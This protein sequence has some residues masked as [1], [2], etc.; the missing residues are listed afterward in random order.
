MAKDKYE[1]IKL[2]N[3]VCFPIYL[4]SKEI[5]KKYNPLLSEL[6]LTY[7]QY[8]VMMFFWERESSNLKE[9][10]QTLMIDPSTL[11]PLLKKIE[12]KGYIKRERAKDDERNLVITLTE[13][14]EALKD[15]ALVIPDK[16]RKCVDMSDDEI[17]QLLALTK[18]LLFILADEK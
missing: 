12:K 16:M 9:L 4:C 2:K 1:S 18:K 17:H 5:I 14:G 13:E 3:Q 11:T 8:V 6:D 15:K 10:A 7:T